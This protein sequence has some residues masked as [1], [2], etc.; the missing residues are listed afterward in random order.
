MHDDSSTDLGDEMSGLSEALVGVVLQSI[1]AEDWSA[2]NAAL[3]PYLHW[4]DANGR[5]RGRSKV[6]A[7]IR[8]HPTTESPSSYEVRDGQVYRWTASS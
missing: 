6:I 7:H 8:A 1:A 2:L 3:H 5:L 4:T